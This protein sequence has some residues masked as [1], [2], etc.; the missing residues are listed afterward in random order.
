MSERHNFFANRAARLQFTKSAK[1]FDRI[2]LERRFKW[3]VVDVFTQLEGDGH[4]N[5]WARTAALLRVSRDTIKQILL[6]FEE[7]GDLSEHDG[8]RHSDADNGDDKR[9]PAVAPALRV[10]SEV[11]RR[12]LSF[13]RARQAKG[14]PTCALDV[15]D[16]VLGPLGQADVSVRTVQR[17]LGRLGLCSTDKPIENPN[18]H[19]TEHHYV[20]KDRWNFISTVCEHLFLG[21]RVCYTDECYVWEH[22]TKDMLSWVDP[23]CPY[24]GEARGR[25]AS[26]IGAVFHD[27]EFVPESIKVFEHYRLENKDLTLYPM[28]AND[29]DGDGNGEASDEDGPESDDVGDDFQE[30]LDL[31]VEKLDEDNVGQNKSKRRRRE[32]ANVTLET[33]FLASMEFCMAG[34]ILPIDDQTVVNELRDRGYDVDDVKK[35]VHNVRLKRE[36]AI[37]PVEITPEDQWPEYVLEVPGGPLCVFCETPLVTKSLCDRFC[38]RMCN[39]HNGYDEISNA[40]GVTFGIRQGAGASTRSA[41]P[42]GDARADDESGAAASSSAAAGAAAASSAATTDTQ[43]S[44]GAGS[45]DYKPGKIGAGSS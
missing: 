37:E 23:H 27:G 35:I 34:R 29:A 42:K 22:P 1:Q 33:I 26:V 5:H 39:V 31:Y 9:R 44:A 11:G 15:L 45:R 40:Y 13:V 4:G 6:E 18:T 12:T 17:F 14:E 41:E 25:R 16:N 19:W 43:Q 10:D 36:L 7:T 3:T 32:A 21:G 2:A 24:R 20:R 28:Y 38:C 8:R 30:F